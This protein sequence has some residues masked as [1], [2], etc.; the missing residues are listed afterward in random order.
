MT[1]LERYSIS[2]RTWRS[3]IIAGMAIVLSALSFESSAY[4]DATTGLW[5]DV[6][7]PVMSARDPSKDAAL[8][9]GV[10]RY[11]AL[12]KVTGAADTARDWE[13]YF[14][15]GR[16]VP[17]ERVRL[18]TDQ[19]ATVELIT[20]RAKELASSVEAGGTLFVVFIGHGAPAAAG[21]RGLLVGAD[22]RA[23][24]SS[25]G[26]RSLDY[27]QLLAA[28][29]GGQQERTVMV[30]D[31][32]FSGIAANGRTLLPDVQPVVATKLLATAKT[33]I[34]SAGE[35]GEYAGSLPG[36]QRPALSYLVLGALRGWGDLD[37]DGK[38]TVNEAH[39]Y[40]SMVLRALP[41]THEQHPQLS[42][43][44]PD[45][46]LEQGVKEKGPDLPTLRTKLDTWKPPVDAAPQE[47]RLRVAVGCGD[48]EPKGT[49]DG[50]AV[51]IDNSPTVAPTA[52]GEKRWDD[53]LRRNVVEHI[54]FAIAPGDHHVV[55]RL[56]DCE[57]A[58]VDVHVADA[59]GAD[60]VGVLRP[61]L[62][63][64]RGPAGR[65]NWGR[66]GVALWNVRAL[67]SFNNYGHVSISSGYV[68]YKPNVTGALVQPALAFRW[69][70]LGL[71]L[72]YAGG[73][74]TLTGDI[75]PGSASSFT[76]RP[77][78]WIRAGLRAGARFPFHFAA[79]ML[80]VGGGYDNVAVSEIPHS[81]VASSG[82]V[83]KTAPGGAYAGGW[84]TLDVQPFCDWSLFGSFNF[85]VL[86]PEASTGNAL[87]GMGLSAGVAY[88][89][90]HA[91]TV[92]R[93]VKY[94]L[95]AQ[96]QR[97]REVAKR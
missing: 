25:L 95:G 53:E 89:P 48:T 67:D 66:L 38:V 61:E 29:A 32:C 65:P 4:A 82:S 24:E 43:D 9:I 54:A 46:P 42:T 41:N 34:L 50:L 1:L 36:S 96:P 94:K 47:P 37:G 92:E 87:T 12:P 79:L 21:H 16:R 90:N 52:G 62:S 83:A 91:C 23:S 14:L 31:A 2:R 71:D 44:A 51:Y 64:L 57:P 8:V 60:V 70:T 49:D 7:A 58:E 86:L 33:T 63:L 73:T 80:G 20:S 68:H 74:T 72:G 3:V 28:V 55:V 93:S 17:P 10:E 15:L 40:A 75:P 45:E 30:L 35:A 39:A 27:E 84:A 59:S 76:D 13:R 85:D 97:T 56:P 5:P 19:N 22:A 18:L 6:S 78:T 69:W 77:T 11:D 26:S 88:Q 81:P